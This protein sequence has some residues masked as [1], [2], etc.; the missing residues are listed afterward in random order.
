[1]IATVSNTRTQTTTFSAIAETVATPFNVEPLR[2]C[3]G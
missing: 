1:M 2:C 3:T